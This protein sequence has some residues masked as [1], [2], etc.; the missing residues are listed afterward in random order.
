M[1]GMRKD[2]KKTK[3]Y[4]PFRKK[5]HKALYCIYVIIATS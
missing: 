5:T 2:K 3:D 1:S 4:S